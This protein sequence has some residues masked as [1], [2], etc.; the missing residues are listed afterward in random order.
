MLNWYEGVDFLTK[1]V[2]N[3]KRMYGLKGGNWMNDDVKVQIRSTVLEGLGKR[4]AMFMLLWIQ[5]LQKL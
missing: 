4:K 5:Q 3:R 1:S 2:Y